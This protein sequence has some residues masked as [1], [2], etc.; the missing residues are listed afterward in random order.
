MVTRNTPCLIIIYSDEVIK[1]CMDRYL[2]SVFNGNRYLPRGS[3][4]NV[5]SIIAITRNVLDSS[6]SSKYTIFGFCHDSLN[7][8]AYI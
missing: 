5:L 6:A 8:V 3:K 1:I 4:E 2:L 7:R